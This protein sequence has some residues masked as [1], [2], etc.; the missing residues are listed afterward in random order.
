[1]LSVASRRLNINASRVNF[2]NLVRPVKI[3]GLVSSHPACN[4]LAKHAG[5][6]ML[7]PQVD[8]D[9]G[10]VSS[11][12]TNHTEPLEVLEQYIDKAKGQWCLG[13]LDGH[14]FLLALALS[15]KFVVLLVTGPFVCW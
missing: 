11:I 1:M 3:V 12:F 9:D 7:L 6:L 13:D 5:K 4:T 15:S 2:C 8:I 10:A 14:K